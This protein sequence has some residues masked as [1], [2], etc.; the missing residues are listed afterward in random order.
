MSTTEWAE[1]YRGMSSK[2][3]ALPGRYNA[4]LT[5]WVKGM[6][7]ALDDKKIVRVVALKSAQVAWTDGVLLNYM[8]RRI[9]ID[10]VPMIVMF[11]KDNAAKDFNAEKLVPMIEATPRLAA[12]IPVGAKRDKDNKW[13]IKG[14]P[15]GFLK[16]VGSNSPSNVKST[17]APVVCVEEPD[18]CNDNIKQQGNTIKLLEERTKTFPRRKVL[19]GGTPTIRG[20]SKIE[21]AYNESDQRKFFVPCPICGEEQVLTWESV[22]WDEREDLQHEI[23]GKADLDSAAYV[24]PHCG[25]IWNDAMKN[26]AVKKGRW[27]ATAPFV[28]T[29][30]FYINEIY[31]PFPGSTFKN[32]VTKYLS[33]K[34]R[35]DAEGEDADMRSF[36]NNQLGLPYSFDSG[37]PEPNDIK[38]RAEE[39]DELTVPKNGTVLTAGVDVQHDRLAIIIRAWGPGEESWLV[40]WGEIYGQT[41]LPEEG[42]WRDLDELL[43]R[44]YKN[45]A[46]A[47]LHIKAVS[48]DSS[49]GQTS[50]AVY[51][52]VRKRKGRG[53]M[54]IK[55]SSVNDDSKE[56]FT[57]PRPSVD[58]NARQKAKKY[59]LR[60]FIVGTARAKD[61]ILGVN[62]NAGR[63]KLT[64]DGPGRLHWYKGVREDYWEQLLSEVKAPGRLSKKLVWQ[65]KTGVRNEALDCEVYALHAARSLKLFTWSQARW[66]LEMSAQTQPDLFESSG[67]R[68]EVPDALPD[69]PTQKI[70]A[71]A[72]K[73]KPKEPAPKPQRKINDEYNDD[74]GFAQ[75][76]NFGD[77]G[78]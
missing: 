2:S 34:H 4:A 50:D 44:S 21:A 31:S 57:T 54:A 29:A 20:L 43:S 70:E 15:G 45:P 69:E 33:A 49:D 58:L 37:L 18:D 74:E 73:P 38:E 23:F 66:D 24:C 52:F 71:P 61:L 26:R 3:T 8:G 68:E 9:D 10:P 60:P 67:T 6:H 19:F 78:W 12:K 36:I 47:D 72:E 16:L 76:G 11:S 5:P 13:N 63:V 46:G 51:S 40:F 35:L 39:Y 42:A 1:K 64:G 27:I 30:G 25:G 14:F 28:E 55:G 48:I 62:A 32:L 59:G 53:I 17:P 56:I 22:H 41:M 77:F 65:K 7:E 75:F